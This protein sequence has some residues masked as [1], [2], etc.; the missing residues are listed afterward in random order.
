[1]TFVMKELFEKDLQTVME[2]VEDI[3]RTAL[4]NKRCACLKGLTENFDAEQ[5]ERFQRYTEADSDIDVEVMKRLYALAFK[6][7]VHFALDLI[8]KPNKP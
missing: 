6:K 8:E 5:M 3:K 1:M 7:G 4:W 2:N